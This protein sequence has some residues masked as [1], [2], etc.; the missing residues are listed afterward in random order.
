[1]LNAGQT[2]LRYHKMYLLSTTNNTSSCSAIAYGQNALTGSEKL[3]FYISNYTTSKQPITVTPRMYA[4]RDLDG[5]RV[6]LWRGEPLEM[7]RG[8]STES[9]PYTVTSW[10]ADLPVGQYTIYA[11]TTDELG[12]Y[13]KKLSTLSVVS[14]K[15]WCSVM[16]TFRGDGRCAVIL[17]CSGPEGSLPFGVEYRK[18]GQEEANRVSANLYLNKG[19]ITSFCISFESDASAK[20]SFRAFCEA[21]DG[22]IYTD[23]CECP[24]PAAQLLTL[25]TQKTGSAG[26]TVWEFFAPEDG[27]YVLSLKSTALAEVY[28]TSRTYQS[29]VL[30]DDPMA[31]NFYLKKGESTLIRIQTEG[32][33]TIGFTTIPELEL[34]QTTS[35]LYKTGDSERCFRFTAP[36]DGV[37]LFTAAGESYAAVYIS[38]GSVTRWE[39]RGALQS[40]SPA[41]A[42]MELKKGQTAYVRLQYMTRDYRYS[43]S[44]SRPAPDVSVSDEGVR[45]SYDPECTGLHLIALY[46]TDGRMVDAQSVSVQSL[47]MHISVVL[48]GT[49]T[50]FVRVF[51]LDAEKNTPCTAAK[52]IALPAA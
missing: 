49:Q 45:I 39:R 29:G 26:E 13:S 16:Q 15:P 52:Q 31:R 2:A 12:V 41:V 25:D 48:R 47:D 37:Y 21:D 44:V 50:G 28:E 32:S 7:K 11:E 1:M 33:Y 23:W 42:G 51:Q 38:D 34:G 43:V 40:G 17:A 46:D 20:Y 36:A 9:T 5:L 10:E 19:Y 6:D 24:A 22:T 27:V 4:L 18:D 8:D 3:S 14:D 30:S 35:C